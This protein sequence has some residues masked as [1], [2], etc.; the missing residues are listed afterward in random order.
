MNTQCGATGNITYN[1]ERTQQF[2]CIYID[3]QIFEQCADKKLVTVYKYQ[4]Q[5]RF[6]W[7]NRCK[8]LNIYKQTQEDIYLVRHASNVLG[9][10]V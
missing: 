4:E 10:Y 7:R 1:K 3:L 9:L 8:T 6:A 2:S 5:N